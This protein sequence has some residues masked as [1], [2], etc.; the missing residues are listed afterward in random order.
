MAGGEVYFEKLRPPEVADCLVRGSTFIKWDDV[1]IK[2]A[3]ISVCF[4]RRKAIAELA[5]VRTNAILRDVHTAR[6][7]NF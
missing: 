7:S 3:E 5:H 2:T 1:S 4:G 6:V